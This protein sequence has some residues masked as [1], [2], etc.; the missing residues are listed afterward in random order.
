MLIALVVRTNNSTYLAY[1]N[2]LFSILVY[3]T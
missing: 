1:I 3:N 2:I